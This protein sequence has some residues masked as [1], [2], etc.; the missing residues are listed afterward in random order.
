MNLPVSLLAV[1]C[2][3]AGLL[4]QRP[5]DW[6]QAERRLT[7]DGGASLLSY[8]FVPPLDDAENDRI[9][10]AADYEYSEDDF[11]RMSE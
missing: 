1:V 3:L 6:R 9:L 10:R 8:N 11:R 7:F 4:Q 5:E 2:L